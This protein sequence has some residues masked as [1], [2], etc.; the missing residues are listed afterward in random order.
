MIQVVRAFASIYHTTVL[1]TWQYV[2]PPP[3]H[4]CDGTLAAAAALMAAGSCWLMRDLRHHHCASSRLTTL[5]SAADSVLITIT[6][7]AAPRTHVTDNDQGPGRATAAR[8]RHCGP[9]SCFHCPQCRGLELQPRC[10]VSHVHFAGRKPGPVVALQPSAA[11]VAATDMVAFRSQ[12]VRTSEHAQRCQVTRRLMQSYTCE[13][14]VIAK[15][16]ALQKC[17]HYT[18]NAFRSLAHAKY[19]AGN[20]SAIAYTAC[21]RL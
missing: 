19:S 13:T 6:P 9:K 10:S 16:G 3:P 2:S 8:T 15:W 17:T 11:W 20:L 21:G 1:Y 5:A 14:M 7:Q 4:R 12:N 18:Y